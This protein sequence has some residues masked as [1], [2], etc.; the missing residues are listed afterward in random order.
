VPEYAAIEGAEEGLDDHVLPLA[1]HR[2]ISKHRAKKSKEDEHHAVDTYACMY[3][4]MYVCMYVIYI[5]MYVCMYV[6]MCV[7][8]YI[9]TYIHT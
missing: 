8:V 5:R 3:I 4:C 9:H 1:R 2:S 7:Y 6:C